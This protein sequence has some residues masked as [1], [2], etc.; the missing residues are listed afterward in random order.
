MRPLI[1]AALPATRRLLLPPSTSKSSPTLPVCGT[2]ELKKCKILICLL[3]VLCKRYMGTL[4][5]A[6]PGLE[7]G[8]WRVA[9]WRRERKW[10]GMR[11]CATYV[12]EPCGPEA[13]S[14]LCCFTLAYAC[15]VSL[16]GSPSVSTCLPAHR[17]RAQ[18]ERGLRWA[19]P[20]PCRTKHL[21]APTPGA[22]VFLR[23]AC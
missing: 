8:S 17:L 3:A 15:A 20:L 9:A 7:L 5:P 16:C 6:R 22:C 4:G 21:R 10:R 1:P 23:A 2:H 12:F 13:V 18:L 19:V 14:F 11:T